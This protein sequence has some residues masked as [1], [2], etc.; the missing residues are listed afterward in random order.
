MRSLRRRDTTEVYRHLDDLEPP[1]GT[2]ASILPVYNPPMTTPLFCIFLAFLL[3]MVSKGPVAAAMARQDRGYDNKNPRDQQAE[4][5]GWG[6][7][8]LAAHLNGFEA[9]AAAVLVAFLAGADPVWSARLAVIFVVARVLYLP[10]YI[11]NLDLLRSGV[12]GIG[13]IATAG[14]FLLP[15]LG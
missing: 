4:L 7:R 15:L 8:A 14:L 11:G 1:L 2:S 9:F 13:F 12:W 5:V 3:N 6:R 10:L